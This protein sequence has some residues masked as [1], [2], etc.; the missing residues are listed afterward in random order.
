MFGVV[1]HEPVAGREVIMKQDQYH[2][3]NL[4]ILLGVHFAFEDTNFTCG[5]GEGVCTTKHVAS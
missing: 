3:K 4:G 5:L 2:F 1:L